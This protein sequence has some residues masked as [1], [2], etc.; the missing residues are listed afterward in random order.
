MSGLTGRTRAAT[1]RPEKV[2]VPLDGSSLGESVLA[3][4]T[5]FARLRPQ[6][7]LLLH[8]FTPGLWQGRA[9]AYHDLSLQRTRMERYLERVSRRLQ[10]RGLETR[11]LVRS[12]DPAQEIVDAA[13]R[14]GVDLIA[15][16]THGRTGFRRALLG[17]VAEEVVR[18]ARR[19]VLL[20]RVGR[21]HRARA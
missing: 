21:R 16:S 2:L 6:A 9:V 3:T 14:H 10:R 5:R 17:S 13:R 8:V 18:R 19:P 12:G 1:P 20:V 11:T 15:M 4:L 7:L